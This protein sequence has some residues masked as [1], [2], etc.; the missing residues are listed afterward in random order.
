MQRPVMNPMFMEEKEAP[1][2]RRKPRLL[3]RVWGWTRAG[4]KWVAR[5]FFTNFFRSER[6]RLRVANTLVPMEASLFHPDPIGLTLPPRP[7]R[8]LAS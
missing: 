2:P 7:L 5:I 6:A 3:Q 8:A 1:A 4:L